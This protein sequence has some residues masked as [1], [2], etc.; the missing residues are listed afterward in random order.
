MPT[1][2]ASGVY[3]VIGENAE[4]APAN[5][6]AVSNQ[7]ILIGHDGVILIDTGTS[8]RYGAALIATVRRLTA[9]PIVLAID[10]H[11]HP[12]FIFGNGALASQ[13]VP[14]LAHRDA[15][16]LIRQRCQRCLTQL[17]Q[18]LG[19]DEMDG[20]EVTVPTRLIDGATT[21]TVAGR[22]LEIVY[23]GHSSSPGAIGVLDVASGVLFAGGLVSIDRVPDTKDGRIGN[24]LT[25]LKGIQL[26]KPAMV[27]PGEGP[28]VP[29][30][31]LDSMA[32]Y[33]RSLQAT[34]GK[35]VGDGV[36]LS[37]APQL[38]QLPQYAD[39][40]L[41]RPLHAKNIAQLYLQMERAVMANETGD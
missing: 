30:A 36:G 38:G 9:K 8:R 7:G 14:I 40:P 17:Q 2:L 34:V 15:A 10:T 35:L 16:D 5:Q 37:D 13:G 28:I 11:Q 18:I 4:P 31:R 41:Y 20:T 22:V 29:A 3:A 25:A 33:L 21:F 26:K 23:F 12:A 6:G 24:W 1:E 39:W 32:G 19:A 27:V